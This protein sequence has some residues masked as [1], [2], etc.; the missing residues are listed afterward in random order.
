LEKREKVKEEENP[1]GGFPGK[2]NNNHWKKK[3]QE[4]I[5]FLV[6]WLLTVLS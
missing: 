3:K 5:F 2:G 1:I 6:S 4:N